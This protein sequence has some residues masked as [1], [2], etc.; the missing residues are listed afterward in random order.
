MHAARRT[1]GSRKGKSQKKEE[2]KE[3]DSFS[4]SDDRPLPAELMMVSPTP[5]STCLSRLLLFSPRSK[6]HLEQ[7]KE[8]SVYEG[9]LESV[10]AGAGDA[11]AAPAAANGDAK[12]PTAS[13]STLVARLRI[14][15]KLSAADGKALPAERPMDSL[16]L[17]AG[18][19][20]SLD[21]RDV[22]LGAE[23]VVAVG[24]G[25]AFGELGTDAEIGAGKGG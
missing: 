25:G 21:A 9:V 15:S 24:A 12:S 18:D 8:G 10:S 4:V 17:A 11:A 5:L 23:G 13:P 7:T 2:K 20:V 22:R 19:L 14:V 6:H 3:N 16:D 1:H